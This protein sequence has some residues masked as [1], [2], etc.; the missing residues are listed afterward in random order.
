MIQGDSERGQ[1]DFVAGRKIR[2]ITNQVGNEGKWIPAYA[3]MTSRRGEDR[4]SH[5]RPSAEGLPQNDKS[6][7]SGRRG[8]ENE[9]EN[10]GNIV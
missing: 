6:E 2:W 3:G 8:K 5:G 1:G 7:K 4:D 9:D 10:T